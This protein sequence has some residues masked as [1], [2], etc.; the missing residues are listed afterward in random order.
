[1]EPTDTSVT[2]KCPKCGASGSIVNYSEY[3]CEQ[4]HYWIVG[5]PL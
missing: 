5:G 4:G 2:N 1:M 3:K